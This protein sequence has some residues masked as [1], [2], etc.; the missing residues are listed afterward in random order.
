MLVPSRDTHTYRTLAKL[1]NA[2]SYERLFAE[3]IEVFAQRRAELQSMITSYIAAG[4]DAANIGI[5]DVGRKINVLDK[6]IDFLVSI[7]RQLDTPC[8]QDVLRFMEQNGGAQKCVEK[9]ELLMKLLTKAGESSGEGKVAIIE[10]DELAEIRDTLTAELEQ[11]K[12]IK[13]VLAENLPRFT[14]ILNVQ[15]N[16]LKLMTDHLEEQGQEMQE[17][18]LKLDQLVQTSILILEEGRLIKKAV[19]PN[20]SM[21]LKDPVLQQIWDRVVRYSSRRSISY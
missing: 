14:K 9:D 19:A 6:K 21:T 13:S 17:Q 2:K 4:V 20:A 8:E 1:I 12:D 3:H 18:T 7:F 11:A 10:G 15:N 16:N 5:A